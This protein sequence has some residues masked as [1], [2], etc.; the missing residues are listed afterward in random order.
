[1][2]SSGDGAHVADRGPQLITVLWVMTGLSTLT[3]ALRFASR[4]MRR[5]VG[6]DDFMMLFSLVCAVV[7]ELTMDGWV[8]K[9]DRYHSSVSMGGRYRS[10]F[11][12]SMEVNAT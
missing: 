1:M 10:P 8:L 9:V 3:V 11:S 5:S 7:C 2:D 6:W 12:R 4:S